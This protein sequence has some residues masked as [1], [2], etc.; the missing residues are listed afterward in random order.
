MLMLSA[1]SSV[2]Q[3]DVLQL[4]HGESAQVSVDDQNGQRSVL[5]LVE[6]ADLAFSRYRPKTDLTRNIEQA[7]GCE[8]SDY[9]FIV[10]RY[11]WAVCQ[12]VI[13]DTMP[14]IVDLDDFRYRYSPESRWSWAALKERLAKAFAHR[15]VCRQLKRFDG[16]FVVSAQ[17]RREIS[18]LPTAFL[19]NVS[20]STCVDPTPVPHSKN[21]LFVGSL[22]YRPN[23]DAVDWFL[24]HVWPQ[25]HAQESEATLTLVGA[26]PQST[27]ARW[28]IHPGVSAPGFVDDLAATY[29]GANL[30]VVPIHSGGGTNIKVLEAMAHGRPC[31]VSSFV[32]K[33]FDGHLSDNRELLVANNA[34]EFSSK[35]LAALG[36]QDNLQGVADAG[37]LAA[38]KYFTRSIFKLRV[39]DFVQQVLLNKVDFND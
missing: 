15:L 9:Q 31:L 18:S 35:T 38:G 21:V 16:A 29:Q 19:P 14:V 10:G 37:Y 26:A 13:P 4:K 3:V 39:T 17:D 36:M 23:A 12:L 22:W 7:L 5:A 6:G 27:R 1:L 24:S 20:L 32:A 11:V 2:G 8:M 34:Q 28:A 25:V 30:V 33:A